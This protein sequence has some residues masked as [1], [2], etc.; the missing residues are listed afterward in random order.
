VFDGTIAFRSLVTEQTVHLIARKEKGRDQV[1]PGIPERTSHKASVHSD[2]III[3]LGTE[4]LTQ[5]HLENF[6]SPD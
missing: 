3:T 2:S 6:Q 5:E 4:L 1:P